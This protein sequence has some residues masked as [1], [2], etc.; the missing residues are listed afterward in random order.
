[1]C[2]IPFAGLPLFAGVSAKVPLGIVYLS[3]EAFLQL[4]NIDS[5]RCK[6]FIDGAH[7]SIPCS[8]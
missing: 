3:L 1:M 8:G 5:D 7:L 6:A 2:W 4:V